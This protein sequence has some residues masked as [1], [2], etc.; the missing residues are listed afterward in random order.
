VTAPKLYAPDLLIWGQKNA[1]GIDS[2]KLEKAVVTKYFEPSWKLTRVSFSNVEY[3]T[4]GIFS[5]LKIETESRWKYTRGQ[6]RRLTMK[7]NIQGELSLYSQ[8]SEGVCVSLSLQ[9][10]L[11]GGFSLYSQSSWGS[12]AMREVSLYYTVPF[13]RILLLKAVSAEHRSKLWWRPPLRWKIARAAQKYQTN[14]ILKMRD[15]E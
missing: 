4:W 10:E 8:T 11:R 14:L 7:P 6:G 15:D 12:L 9:P 3:W 5:P 1:D 2:K 13:S